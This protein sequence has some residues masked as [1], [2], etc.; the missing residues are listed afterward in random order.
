M[1]FLSEMIRAPAVKAREKL[2]AAEKQLIS[3][4]F[5]KIIADE[6]GATDKNLKV[7]ETSY[8]LVHVKIWSLFHW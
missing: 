6:N 2:R 8:N 7:R 3:R 4:I 5:Q 1:L